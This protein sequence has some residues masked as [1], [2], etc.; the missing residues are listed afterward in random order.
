VSAQQQAVVTFTG[1]MQ[2]NVQSS[3]LANTIGSGPGQT[4]PYMQGNAAPLGAA[5]Q[6]YYASMV[7]T[8]ELVQVSV[9][10]NIVDPTNPWNTMALFRIATASL[11][12]VDSESTTQ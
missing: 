3:P 4:V 10:S 12:L 9:V 8:D 11:I 5:I 7:L 6:T 1:M 2:G